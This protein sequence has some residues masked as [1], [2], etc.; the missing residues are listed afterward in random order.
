MA[1][2]PRR[3]SDQ[4][5]A[6]AAGRSPPAAGLAGDSRRRTVVASPPSRRPGRTSAGWRCS[7]WSALIALNF[8]IS[9]QALARARGS[10][11]RTA[12]PSSTR[13]RTTTS[14]R[15][16]RPAHR[17]TGRSRS[18]SSTPPA[19]T[20]TRY[21]STQIPS[22]ASNEQLFTLLQ[23][24]NV[25]INAQPTNTGPSFL[26]SLI[27]GFGPTLLFLL[28]LVWVFRRAASAGGGAGGLMSFGRS[29]ARRVEGHDQR[30]TFN[31][32]AG[33][34]RGQGGADR[35]RRL[36]QEPGQVPEA[37]RPDPARRAAERPARHRQDAA[38]S[39]RR[40]RGGRAVLPDVRVGVRRDDRRRRRLARTRPVR[41]GQG[42]RPRRSSSSTSSTRSAARAPRAGRTSPV[43]TTSASRRS[44]RSSPRWTG[45]TRGSE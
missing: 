38:G 7:W 26:T 45:S 5:Q 11:S 23:K 15:S 33:H 44:T 20:A 32:V 17:S 1:E 27:F 12:R 28:L 2:Q 34:R 8:W 39:G 22:F 14:S 35:D 16:P 18:R 29:R 9:S 13:P 37:R 6:A 30:V 36:P 40:R 25:T 31:D 10:G 19:A 4:P 41:P 3:R 21:F 43:A 42:R 24:N